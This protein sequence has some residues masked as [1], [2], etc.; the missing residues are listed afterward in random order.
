VA[1]V[2]GNNPRC[3]Q[4]DV[5][6]PALFSEEARVL[7]EQPVRFV[8]SA[9]LALEPNEPE[10]HQCVEGIESVLLRATPVVLIE[11]ARFVEAARKE[12]SIRHYPRR[13][14]KIRPFSRVV[15]QRERAADEVVG[16]GIAGDVL[17][18]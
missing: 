5:T 13:R 18:P 6:A 11:A 17:E 3:V 1:R 10:R 9:R 8:E 4:A 7:G 12:Q 2:R 16:D 14:V 15:L